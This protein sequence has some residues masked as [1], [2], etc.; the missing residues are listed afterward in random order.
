MERFIAF[1]LCLVFLVHCAVSHPSL[2]LEESDLEPITAN[3]SND[4]LVFAHVVS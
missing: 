1:I 2:F 3:Q 4:T